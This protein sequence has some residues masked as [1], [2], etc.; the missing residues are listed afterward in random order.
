[1]RYRR[2]KILLLIAAGTLYPVLNSTATGWLTISGQPQRTKAK[3]RSSSATT[4]DRQRDY[5]NFTHQVP[6]HKQACNLCHK[7]PS[8]NWKQIRKGDEAFPDVTDYP[9]HSSCLGCHRDQF[10]SGATPTICGVCHVQPGP[11]N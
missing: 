1:M 8:A 2:T 7:F 9:Q 6:Q 10:F 5:S 4:S 11:R 3:T